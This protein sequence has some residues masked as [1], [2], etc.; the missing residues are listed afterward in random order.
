[1]SQGPRTKG[2]R[3]ELRFVCSYKNLQKT[4]EYILRAE[5]LDKELVRS[6]ES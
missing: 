2:I 6:G 5:F 4:E 3:N 1:M